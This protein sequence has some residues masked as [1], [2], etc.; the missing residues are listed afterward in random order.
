MNYLINY[1][2]VKEK[3]PEDTRK[4]ILE[5]IK[6]FYNI[7][8]YNTKYRNIELVNICLYLSMFKIDTIIKKS[9][10]NN[11]MYYEDMIK[12]LG[13][14]DI[15]IKELDNKTMRKTYESYFK[16]LISSIYLVFDFYERYLPYKKFDIEYIA[17][18]L[19]DHKLC[20]TTVLEE[21]ICETYKS[22]YK[23]VASNKIIQFLYDEGIEK[24][25]PIIGIDLEEQ[26]EPLNSNGDLISLAN[27]FSE[28]S[29]NREAILNALTAILD[30]HESDEPIDESDKG[31]I[32]FF[33]PKK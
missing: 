3:V 33:K 4:L 31:K 2:T 28:K 30:N 11:D 29:N 19:H 8:E 27:S 1:S 32:L 24:E 21:L 17:R 10:N 22:P 6:M 26:N 18:S 23:Y 12:Y 7:K 25:E 16:K 20:E 15:E 13:Y 14:K 9:M 5:A